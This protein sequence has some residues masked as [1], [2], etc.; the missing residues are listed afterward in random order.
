M[1][2][3]PATDDLEP[4]GMSSLYVVAA[5]QLDRQFRGLCPR[6]HK[7]DMGHPLGGKVADDPLGQT[8]GRG[9]LNAEMWA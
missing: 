7:V 5:G 1:V 8:N 4:G 3:S 2:A 6:G 9:G